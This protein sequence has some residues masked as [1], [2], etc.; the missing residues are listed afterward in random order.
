MCG[1]PSPP[2]SSK[3]C[4]FGPMSTLAFP[5]CKAKNGFIELAARESSRQLGYDSLE[6]IFTHVRLHVVDKGGGYY[7]VVF[8]TGDA[9]VEG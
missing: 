4:G 6:L 9:M 2:A 5:M 1:L 8:L 3:D 7:H